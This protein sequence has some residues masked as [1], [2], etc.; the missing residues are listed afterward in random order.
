[1]GK[2]LLIQTLMNVVMTFASAEVMKAAVDGLLDVIEDA[3]AK[4]E[5]KI[6]DTI[7]LPVCKQ[8][9]EVFNVPDND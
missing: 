2:Q 1:M 5:N 3:V 7:V 4:S 8:V 6:D 9:R